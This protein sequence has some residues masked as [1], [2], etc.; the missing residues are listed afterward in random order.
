MWSERDPHCSG[1]A[2]VSKNGKIK[3]VAVA[4]LVQMKVVTGLCL[5]TNEPHATKQSDKS[6]HEQVKSNCSLTLPS[7]SSVKVFN[8]SWCWG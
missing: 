5:L 8:L 4:D 1:L 2:P 6:C 3:V 7:S